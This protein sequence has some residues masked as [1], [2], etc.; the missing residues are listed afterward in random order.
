M[1]YSVDPYTGLRLYELSHVWGHGVP[2]MPGDD[3][4]KMY[5]SVKHGQH[6]V[7]THRISMVMHSG[8]HL[9]APIHLIQGG[10]STADV[11]LDCFFGNGVIL[12]IPKGKWELISKEDVQAASPEIQKGDIVVIVTGW[13][14]KY[15]D[16][17]EYWGESPGISK[18]AAQWLISMKIRM[19]AIDTP[20]VD[21]PLATSLGDHRGG[22]L[23]N[24]VVSKYEIETGRSAKD[25]FPDWNIAHKIILGS[26]IP[27][28]EQVG[29]DVDDLLGK[30][31]TF[32]ATPWRSKFGD[33][34]PVRFIAM[35]DT[36]GLC[37]I[38]DGKENK[39]DE[40]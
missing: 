18:E 28:I 27:T 33:A 3:D 30:R 9:N 14:H 36:S 34:C 21:H 2:S 25:D 23:M 13:H 1:A 17:L 31:A 10:A 6:G 12:S 39:L 8:T 16:S 38:S 20:Q 4:V 35:I 37:R 32:A 5:R 40:V 19:F 24:R 15:S 29:G 7:M 11:P 26:K 22:P